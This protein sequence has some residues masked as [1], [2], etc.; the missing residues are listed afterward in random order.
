MEVPV[1]SDIKEELPP[2]LIITGEE[3]NGV[4]GN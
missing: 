2:Y 3:V 1:S 4:V